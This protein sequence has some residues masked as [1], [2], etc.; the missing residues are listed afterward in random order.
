[1]LKQLAAASPRRKTVMVAAITAIVVTA[2]AVAVYF[3]D[4][5]AKDERGQVADTTENRSGSGDRDT[6]S[7][8][9][10]GGPVVEQTPTAE[11]TPAAKPPPPATSTAPPKQEATTGRQAATGAG[12]LRGRVAYR[13]EDAV[14]VACEDGRDPVRVAS[15][16]TGPITLS[17]NGA[18]LATVHEGSIVLVNVSTGVA[19][20][21]GPAEAMR[22]VW[23]KDSS[24]VLYVRATSGS[25]SPEVWRLPVSGG[26]AQKIVDGHSPAAAA[27]GTVVAIPP[28]DP[29]KPEAEQAY[30][31]VLR[32]GSA[33]SRSKTA[34]RVNA[35]DVMSG[36]VVYAT[37]GGSMGGTGP[38]IWIA[39]IDGRDSRRVIQGSP[40]NRPFGYSDLRL[41]PTGRHVL[42]TLSG[43]DG[44][45][46]VQVIDLGTG[47][48]THLTV[49]R[50]TY[51]MGWTADGA[52]V[53][54]FEGNVFQGEP[55]SLLGARKDGTG[56]E[57][58]VQGAR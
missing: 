17:P 23:L 26:G 58:I 10:S 5:S 3:Q 11:P 19:S 45:S 32:P 54:F 40:G 22:P 43:D 24:A 37:G 53:R 50:D 47:G 41:S 57:V 49:R 46:R 20:S 44:Y 30:F 15:P 21:A 16:G 12:G 51:P 48:V 8:N 33:L 35:I 55:S 9:A 2:I 25:A 38:A 36:R 39:A 27:D 6:T 4:P 29:A 1:M 56:R 31:W 34:A 28:F 7:A 52:E 13:L 18:F 14:W 42:A